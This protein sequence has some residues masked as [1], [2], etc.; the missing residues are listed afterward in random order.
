MDHDY[1]F[2]DICVGRAGSVHDARVFVNS[3]LYKRITEDGL[4]DGAETLTV[5][6]KQVPVCLIGDSA[7]PISTWLMKPFADSSTLSPRPKHFN[8]RLSSARTVVEIAFGR[9]KAR[10]RRLMKRMRCTLTLSLFQP[11]V[12]YTICVKYMAMG[13]TTCGCRRFVS[14]NNPQR[15]PTQYIVHVCCR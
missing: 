7:Y 1:L 5:A 6:G 10:W 11:A 2:R 9:L 4:L 14:M 13:L 15:H 8:F 12:F 3:L